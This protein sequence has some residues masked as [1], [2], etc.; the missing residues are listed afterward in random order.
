M[1]ELFGKQSFNQPLDFGV[2]VAAGRVVLSVGTTLFQ[3]IFP[4]RMDIADQAFL[5]EQERN[6]RPTARAVG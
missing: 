6:R 2:V 1:A 3:M 5:V 4:A